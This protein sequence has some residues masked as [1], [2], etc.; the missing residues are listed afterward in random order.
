MPLT[1][2]F[3]VFLSAVVFILLVL[4]IDVAD[5]ALS[6]TH[7]ALLQARD[8]TS[9][10]LARGLQSPSRVGKTPKK[11]RLLPREA[12]ENLS[13]NSHRKMVATDF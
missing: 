6:T 3:S 4:R 7:P 13:L 5:L 10:R 12:G 8:L 9:H 11:R 2:S 1:H